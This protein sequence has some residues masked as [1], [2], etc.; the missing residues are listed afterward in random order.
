MGHTGATNRLNQ[1]FLNN[2]IL[3]IQGQLACALLWSAP[4]NTM[5]QTRDITDLFGLYPAALFGDRCRAMM[6]ALG[7][8]TH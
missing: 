3:Y 8:R 4:T 5:G 6:D 1:R 7:D 2:A